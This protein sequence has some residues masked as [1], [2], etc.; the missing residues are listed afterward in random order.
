MSKGIFKKVV[1]V[2]TIATTVVS[3]T[4]LTAVAP[5][6]GAVPADYGLTEGDTIRANTAANDP[7]IYIVNDWG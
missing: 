6:L 7:D 1:G 4:G 2:V 3:L 5:A